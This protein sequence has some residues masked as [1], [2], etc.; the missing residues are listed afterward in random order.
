MKMRYYVWP[1]FPLH[2]AHVSIQS[3]VRQGGQTQ[4]HLLYCSLLRSPNLDLRHVSIRTSVR[5]VQPSQFYRLKVFIPP[6][7]KW[8]KANT[9]WP[10]LAAAFCRFFLGRFRPGAAEQASTPS[11]STCE[12]NLEISFS[13]RWIQAFPCCFLASWFWCD[14]ASVSYWPPAAESKVIWTHW[15]EVRGCIWLPFTFC[16]TAFSTRPSSPC[17]TVYKVGRKRDF[18]R[19]RAPAFWPML[20][21]WALSKTHLEP[22]F[23][24]NENMNYLCLLD[25]CKKTLPGG[26]KHLEI[27]ASLQPCDT[28][29]AARTRFMPSPHLRWHMW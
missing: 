22:T 19:C 24:Y 16:L 6:N 8:R 2:H 14:K 23:I 17:V 5:R 25:P 3:L 29:L 28:S 15:S 1:W 27:F 12:W 10:R 21:T 4:K 13:N 26:H 11:F 18:R 7:K 20:F 9:K